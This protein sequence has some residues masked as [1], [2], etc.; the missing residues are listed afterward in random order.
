MTTG[1]DVRSIVEGY[2]LRVHGSLQ[3]PVSPEEQVE[4]M[5]LMAEEI[6]SMR[7]DRDKMLE[8]LD[9][10]GGMGMGMSVFDVYP[11]SRQW[12]SDV[13]EFRFWYKR[14]HEIPVSLR[15]TGRER[16]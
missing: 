8:L 7:E 14:K 6:L 5:A 10:V 16:R 15:I 4:A 13:N 2:I 11:E 3:P 1:N 12:M 9:A